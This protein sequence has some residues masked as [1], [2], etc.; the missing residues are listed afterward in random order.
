MSPLADLPELVGFFSYSRDDDEAFHGSLSALRDAISREL[1]ARLARNKSDFR[2]FQDREAIAPGKLWEV[3]IAEAIKQ[4]AFFIPIVTPRSVGSPHCKFEFASFRDREKDLG[5]N[6]LIFPILYLEVPQ[7]NDDAKWR[8][9]PVLSVIGQRQYFDWQP[10]RH[11]SIN[12][13]ATGEAIEYFCKKIAIALREPWTSP[14]EIR[15]L[16]EEA[17]LKAIADEESRRQEEAEKDAQAKADKIAEEEKRREVAETLATIE[18][19]AHQRKV[20]EKAKKDQAERDAEDARRR[21][22]AE[23]LAAQEEMALQRKKEAEIAEKEKADRIAKD[24]QRREASEALAAY[25]TA[26]LQ[27][28]EAER[29]AQAEAKLIAELERRKIRCRKFLESLTWWCNRNTAIIAVL[30]LCI[31]ADLRNIGSTPEDISNSGGQL[32]SFDN[33]IGSQT[34][35]EPCLSA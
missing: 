26:V 7:L 11:L 23:K 9:D 27:R 10:F 2:L 5:R 29:A 14:D 15:A 20:A 33:I 16:S 17:R 31:V 28:K 13:T 35:K 4:S 1:G 22:V 19:E 30:V 12:S 25:E 34:L 3:E 6:D 21:A 24:K 18:E 32:P 8:M